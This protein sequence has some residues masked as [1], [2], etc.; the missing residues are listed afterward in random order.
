MNRERR[1]VFWCGLVLLVACAGLLIVSADRR[2]LL[3]ALN[4]L[5]V[6]CGA[7]AVGVPVGTFL[8]LVLC[9]TDLPGR[10]AALGLVT[11]LL[12][13]PLY[14]HAAAWDAGFGKLGWYSLARDALPIPFLSGT[15]AVMWI[16]GLWAVPWVT[17]IVAAALRYSERELEEAALL[18][19]TYVQV[20]LHVTLRRAWP[21]V[22]AACAWVLLVA[23][24]EIVVT[25]LYQVRTLAEE[26]YTGFALANDPA[27]TFGGFTAVV[28]TGALAG[29][30]LMA[31]D[32]WLAETHQVPTR[33]PLV[34]S[35]GRW[36]WPVAWLSGVVLA[37]L[38]VVPVGNLVYQVGLVV[39]QADGVPV[40][41]WS[42]RRF[43]EL[44]VPLPASYP[45]AALW[46]FR[47][48]FGWTVAIGVSAAT[49]SV[50][51]AAPLAWWGRRGGLRAVPAV[52]VAAAGAGIMGPLVGIALIRVFTWSDRSLVVWLYDRTVLAPV[53][54]AT[55]RCLPLAVLICWLA[56]RGL[57]RVLLDAARVDGA[58]PIAR[59]V[60]IGVAQRT[61]A[62][63]VAWLV[64]FSISG[65]ELSATIL[66]VP[67]GV[68][69]V[70]IRVFGLLHSGVTN[71]AAAICLT[72][73]LMYFVV[74]AVIQRLGL[75]AFRQ[76]V[77]GP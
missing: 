35:L 25:D 73:I 69:T 58:G 54:A 42:G 77:A 61:S 17:W 4:T 36:R 64:S 24:S 67:P 34:F 7:C 71:Q 51:L 22:V 55:W 75:Y 32:R 70:P 46:E 13:L 50:V 18:D 56:F 45:F 62:L 3:L 74:A 49:L 26:L 14:L 15:W 59:F 76:V 11:G 5:W 9:R 41:S 38:V 28:W 30:A 66:V 10:R 39:R 48:A 68:T 27:A 29:A 8:A 23:A 37:L 16:H 6:G 12:F 63:A 33:S 43:V 19:A 44:L 1:G 47:R 52:M 57:P 20:F 31:F 2:V 40:S 21:G 53:L 60:R 65:G 72:G